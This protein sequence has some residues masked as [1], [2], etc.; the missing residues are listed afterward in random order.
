MS[1]NQSM[2]VGGLIAAFASGALVGV[3]LALL[4]A[5]QSGRET[6]DLLAR[7]TRE[8]KDKAGNALDVAKNVVRGKKEQIL[9]AVKAGREAF[10]TEGASKPMTA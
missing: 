5:P 7:K 1:E 9:A 3:G 6:R 8:L 2:K 10:E 4:Y